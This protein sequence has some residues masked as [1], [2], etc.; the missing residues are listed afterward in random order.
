MAEMEK[1]AE[2]VYRV[3]AGA[4]AYF[5]DFREKILIDTGEHMHRKELL[6]AL[7]D[8][9]GKVKHVIFT[10]LHYDHMGNIDLFPKAKLYA[11]ETEIQSFVDNP[12]E[13]VLDFERV[14][15]LA[16]QIKRV[17]PAKDLMG[18]KIIDTP[19]HTSG[20]ICVWYAKEKVLFSGDT[21]FTEGI[22]RIDLPTSR[23][24]QMEKTL[25]KIDKIKYKVLCPGH[26]Y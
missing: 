14:K 19:G 16:Q 13:T 20:T 2:K 10:H 24:E 12:F 7:G 22:G 26:E 1:L 4:N 18:L 6:D 5:L 3:T 8:K 23:P 11:S 9:A 15:V 17:L 25:K 21:L